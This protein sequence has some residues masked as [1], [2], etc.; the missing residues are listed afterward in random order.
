VA[1]PGAVTEPG[2]IFG[3]IRCSIQH[4]RSVLVSAV[5]VLSLAAPGLLQLNLQLGGHALVPPNNPAVA[6]DLSVRKTFGQRD[7]IVVFIE[8]PGPGQI[9]DADS[10]RRVNDLTLA[11]FDYDEIESQHIMSLASEGRD[12]VESMDYSPFL[13]PL[14]QTQQDIAALRA[15]I[16][17]APILKGTL[18]APDYSG[19]TILVQ[20]PEGVDRLALYRKIQATATAIDAGDDRVHIVGAPVAEVLLGRHLLDDLALLLPLCGGLFAAAL[21]LAFRRPLAIAVVMAQVGA[22][23]VFTFGLMGWSGQP[24]YITTTILP[25]VLCTMGIASE[26]H[27]MSAVQRC[28]RERG[29]IDARELALAAMADVQRPLTLTVLTT[30]IGF[31][32]FVLS[33]LPPVR[34][35]GLWATIGTLFSLAWSLCVTPALYRVLGAMR[36]DRGCDPPPLMD[37]VIRIIDHSGRFRWL[38]LAAFVLLAA[39]TLRLQIQDGWVSGFAEGSAFRTSVERVN[40]SVLGTHLL[41]VELDFRGASG[42]VPPPFQTAA[43]LEAVRLM[44][45]RLRALD[46]V[47]G[48]IGPYSNLSTTRYLVSG[49]VPGSEALSYSPGEIRRLWRRLEFARGKHRRQEIVDDTMRQGLLTIYLKAANYRQTAAIMTQVRA[50]AD[51]LLAPLGGRVRFAGDVAVS[52]A[53]ISANVRGQLTSIGFGIVSLFVFLLVVLRRIW[54]AVLAVIPVSV[55]CLAVLGSMGWLGVPIGVATS[56]FVAI[57]LGIGV[58]FPLHL[59]ERIERERAAGAPDPVARAKAAVGP[60]LLIDS[61]VVGAGFGLLVVSQVPANS[62]LGALVALSVLVSCA[63]TLLLAR[64]RV[65]AVVR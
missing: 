12:R 31:V 62:R 48:V 28:L 9:L 6:I 15:D 8:S 14:P 61:L 53:A 5:A 35:F 34:S 37:A 18:V 65:A 52:Q 59:I 10:L 50:D 54:A 58:D 3:L 29:I 2:A 44:E 17:A 42:G 1:E 57:T 30:A 4:Y 24:I 41:Q 38:M 47:G 36:L 21:W 46:I 23:L 55:A 39:G 11:I 56:M 51:E 22:C 60:A 20:I 16:E 33:D 45:Q 49:R 63:C 19:A 43:V 40:R 7:Q 26:V 25:V 32:S 13:L 64:D 27:L